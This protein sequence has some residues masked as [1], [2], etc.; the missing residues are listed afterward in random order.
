M[1]SNPTVVKI[2]EI[3]EKNNCEKT[4]LS[5]DVKS[6]HL[7]FISELRSYTFWGGNLEA[8]RTQ[9]SLFNIK[10]RKHSN[11]TAIN[12]KILERVEYMIE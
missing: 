4:L 3:H 9:K 1:P 8:A 11:F 10:G 6:Y 5:S 7:K 2:N 12:M